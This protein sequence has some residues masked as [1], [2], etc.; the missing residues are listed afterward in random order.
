MIRNAVR[1]R[2]FDQLD[3]DGDGK[4]ARSDTPQNLLG[5]FDDLDKNKDKV[6]TREE[7]S[8]AD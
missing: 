8:F 4:L 2:K 6:L 1:I 3:T 7:V 5:V